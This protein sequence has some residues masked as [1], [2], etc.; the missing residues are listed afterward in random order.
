MLLEEGK[1]VAGFPVGIVPGTSVIT[2][3]QGMATVTALQPGRYL[4]RATKL[5]RSTSK[6][7]DWESDF[8]TVTFDVR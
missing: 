7:Y 2:D 1:P 6:D 4:I 5:R 8:A 3:S